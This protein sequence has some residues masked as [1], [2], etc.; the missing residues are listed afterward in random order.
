MIEIPSLRP[1]TRYGIPTADLYLMNREY[2][3]GYSYLFRQPRWAL[4][5]IND[6]TEQIA[7]DLVRLNNFRIDLRVPEKFRSTLKD[8]SSEKDPV[9]KKA[10]WDRGHLV[11]SANR[12]SKLVLNS[13]T[14]LMSNMSPQ[15]RNFNRGIWKELESAVRG[16][17]VP[18]G[19]LCGS[20]CG[21]RSIV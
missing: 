18:G 13:E 5:R 3:I 15:A 16:L 21:M 4:E 7:E 12:R 10:L 9:D 14:F 1:E 8:Y 11:A 17:G 20:V 6:E 19:Y 2:I